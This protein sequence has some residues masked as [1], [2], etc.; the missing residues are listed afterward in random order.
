MQLDRCGRLVCHKVM[1][2]HRAF[3]SDKPFDRFL[4]EQ[5]AGDELAG[6]LS[7]DLSPEQS[8][9]D[10]RALGEAVLAPFR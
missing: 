3:N 5:L 2:P 10:G 7:G 4:Q 8:Q 1:Q 9:A 6:A